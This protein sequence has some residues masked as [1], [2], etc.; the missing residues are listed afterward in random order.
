MMILAIINWILMLNLLGAAK[1]SAFCFQFLCGM[2]PF[3]A[4]SCCRNLKYCCLQYQSWLAPLL[5]PQDLFGNP[6]FGMYPRFNMYDTD[7]YPPP[8]GVVGI[9]G[10]LSPFSP[11]LSRRSADLEDDQ[12]LMQPPLKSS[13]NSNYSTLIHETHHVHRLRR[14]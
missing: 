3:V 4:K 8:P 6:R 14:N 9:M 1:G 2:A 5:G 11:I 7:N 10:G 12:K 13:S